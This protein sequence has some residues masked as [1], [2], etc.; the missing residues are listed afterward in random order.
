[1]KPNYFGQRKKTMELNMTSMIDVIFLL[2]IFFIFTANFDSLEK[3]L[4]TQLNLPGSLENAE[5][6][7]KPLELNA[8]EIQIKIFIKNERLYWNVNQR[9]CSTEREMASILKELKQ[10]DATIPVII[11][12][13]K[14]IA[15]EY[16]IDAYDLCRQ[17]GLSN[18]QFAASPDFQRK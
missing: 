13:Q 14:N 17:T 10:I 4:P 6:Q 18:I 16:V 8:Q 11:D 15:M 7:K 5:Q 9:E 1:M 2:L 12:P 3:L